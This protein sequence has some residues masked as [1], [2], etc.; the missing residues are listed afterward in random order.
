MLGHGGALDRLAPDEFQQIVSGRPSHPERI[1]LKPFRR[2]RR[3]SELRSRVL[4]DEV[5][6]CLTSQVLTSLSTSMATSG[7]LRITSLARCV[8]HPACAARAVS[9][10]SFGDPEFKS[11]RK[12]DPL[13]HI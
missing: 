2:S 9:P 1:Q 13:F 5:M 12:H 7:F 10:S 8:R 11:F 4:A 3:R 6:Q